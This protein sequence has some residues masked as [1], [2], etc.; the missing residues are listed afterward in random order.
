MALGLSVAGDLADALLT[1][2]V[3][4]DT[5]D[6]T[7]Q[8]KPLL[9]MLEKGS[10]TFPGGKDA[11]SSP[12]QGVYM[13]DTAG[14]FAGYTEDDELTFDQAANILRAQYDW[15]EHHAGLIITWTELK[16][17]GI[18][19][20]QNQKTSESSKRELFVL[21][22]VLKNRLN[23]FGES[24]ARSKNLTFWKDG[25]QDA[26]AV[27]GI[28]ALLFSTT[29][30]LGTTGGLS[31]VTYSF[32]RNRAS[33]NLA[34]S[35]ANQTLSK[36]LRK[37]VRQLRRFGGAK[38]NYAICG[39]AFINALEEEV[40]EKGYYTDAGFKTE[41]NTD[42]GMAPI[43]M[44]GLGSFYYD[45]TLD[46]LGQEKYCYICDTR[47]IR[48]RPMEQEGNKIVTPERPY[49]YMVF[50][51][52]MVTTCAIEATQLNCNGVYSIA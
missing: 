4:G 27:D 14:F 39:S 34:F 28:Q 43:Q 31:R 8:D 26:K 11:V 18:H 12:V 21:T 44:K 22:K 2:Y 33:L 3:R 41:S 38:P 10:E 6:Q 24:W 45:P 20:E 25:T 9:R 7:T 48:L 50:L 40:Q 1:F 17:D 5:L 42:I 49:N 15:K 52:S 29:P 23:D 16:K 51:R 19:I 47:R 37:E 35:P 30:E 32:W 46:D 36:F 13:S